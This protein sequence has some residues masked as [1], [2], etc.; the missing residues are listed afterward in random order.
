MRFILAFV[1]IVA[2]I[3]TVDAAIRADWPMAGVAG[4][5]A[6]VAGVFLLRDLRNPDKTRALGLECKV[7]FTMS[8]TRFT[9][10]TGT[11]ARIEPWAKTFGAGWV[12]SLDRLPERGDLT[13]IDAPQRGWV[14]LGPDNLPE[15][16]KITYG[17]TWRSWPVLTARPIDDAMKP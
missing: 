15:K 1:T 10:Q 17:N 16:V 9:T 13:M 14:W 11:P 12:V 2:V 3:L 6:M 4:S 8:D 5:V 7:I